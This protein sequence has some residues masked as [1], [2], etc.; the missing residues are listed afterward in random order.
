MTNNIPG[1]LH[2]AC[3]RQQAEAALG[4]YGVRRAIRTGLLITPWPR[5]VIEAG[6]RLDPLTMAAVA[7]LSAGPSGALCGFAAAR[8]HGCQAGPPGDVEVVVP[9]DTWPRRRS[10]LVVHNGRV[11]PEDIHVIDGLRVLSPDLVISELLCTARSARAALACA[12]Q[13]CELQPAA[14]RAE[15]VAAVTGRLDIRADRRGTI[16]A[17]GLAALITAGVESPP[18]SW[19]RLLVV[20][21]GFPPP[22]VQHEVCD[23]DGVLLW[24][25]DLAWPAIRVALEYDGH[26]AHSGRDADDLA[27]DEDLRRRGWI[28]IRVRADDLRNPRRVLTDL[29]AAFHSR[30]GLLGA[31][32]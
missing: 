23:L 24:R 11:S 9:Y 1:S 6:R 28:V 5:V 12:D 10:G 13:A 21:N 25:L 29:S 20:E 30:G 16:R 31:T 32:A 22:V 15:F 2:G 14:E 8:L 7:L 19:L 27:R 3:T 18:E 26:A 17:Y 4:T